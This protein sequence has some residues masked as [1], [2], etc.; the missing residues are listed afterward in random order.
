MVC[1]IECTNK[2]Y[3]MKTILLLSMLFLLQACGEI[4]SG[5]KKVCD[6]VRKVKP[7]TSIST[8]G[9][10]E[11]PAMIAEPVKMKGDENNILYRII[12]TL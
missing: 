9:D 12:N 1:E 8:S 11:E 2:T 4:A 7:V 5:T 6:G 3:V 10:T